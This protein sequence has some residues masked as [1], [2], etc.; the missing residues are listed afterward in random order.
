MESVRATGL[1]EI[2]DTDVQPALPNGQPRLQHSHNKK[3]TNKRLAYQ[4]GAKHASAEQA[5]HHKPEKPGLT[6]GHIC[7]LQYGQAA[8]LFQRFQR[9]RRLNLLHRFMGE[10]LVIDES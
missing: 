3:G 9:H 6:A 8:R 1:A 4:K 7:K 5:K 2:L 10:Q